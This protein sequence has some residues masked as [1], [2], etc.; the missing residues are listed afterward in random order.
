SGSRGTT[1]F[2][3][4]SAAVSPIMR[5]SSLRSSGV[6]TSA[7][8]RS[9]IKKLPP[10]AA[11]TGACV[12][13]AMTVSLPCGLKPLEYSCRSHASAD[14]HRDD[15]VAAL[16]PLQLGEELR[17]E[18]GSGA[19]QGMAQGHRAAVHV[20]LRR[21]QPGGLDDRQGLAGEGLVQL[22]EVDVLQREA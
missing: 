22:H 15:P 1:S 6:N 18:L 16:P 20:H 17:G 19:A 21:V 14:A 8:V 11:M 7:G 12:S 9:S 3:M 5:C 13:V 10:C 4:N 2:S